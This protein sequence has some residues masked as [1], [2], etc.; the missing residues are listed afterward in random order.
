MF[1][2]S[3]LLEPILMCLFLVDSLS[4]DFFENKTIFSSIL[5]CEVLLNSTLGI[6]CRK[7]FVLHC[8]VQPIIQILLNN[9]CNITYWQ[10]EVINLNHNAVNLI[11]FSNQVS[12]LYKKYT[13]FTTKNLVHTFVFFYGIQ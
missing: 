5:H 1:V 3:G 7:N 12:P 8:K 4:C 6:D 9:S 10:N 2:F 13:C 11:S